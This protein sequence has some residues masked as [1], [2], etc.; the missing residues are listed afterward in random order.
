MFA[1]LSAGPAHRA[2]GPNIAMFARDQAAGVDTGRAT[3]NTDP[4]ERI[5]ALRAYDKFPV[6][7]SDTSKEM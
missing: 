6:T 2:S 3:I 1:L 4:S 7:G 5:E